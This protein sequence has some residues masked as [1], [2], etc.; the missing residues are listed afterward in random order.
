MSDSLFVTFR[1]IAFVLATAM[2][3]KYWVFLLAAPFYSIK[4]GRRKLRMA[5]SGR[6]QKYN[7]L[8]SIIVPAWNEEV[9]IIKTIQSIVDNTYQNIELLVVNDGSSD[10]SD[11]VVR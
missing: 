10:N 5:K 6:L 3:I 7:P 4:E 8:I 11:Q 2:L 9:G 1:N